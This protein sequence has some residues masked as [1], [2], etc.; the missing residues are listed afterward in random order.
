MLQIGISQTRYIEVPIYSDEGVN[1]M[2]WFVKIN[3]I[4]MLE[5][6]LSSRTRRK[7]SSS[8]ELTWFSSNKNLN[9]YISI[10]NNRS[11]LVS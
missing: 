5:L 6:Y 1:S 8:I 2:F 3:E 7:N 10:T 9:N 11:I 4:D